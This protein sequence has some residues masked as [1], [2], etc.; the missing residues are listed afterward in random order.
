MVLGVVL[1]LLGS[2]RPACFSWG[3]CRFYVGK[4]TEGRFLY[5]LCENNAVMAV[6][7]RLV[8][9]KLNAHIHHLI[10]LFC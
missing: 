7:Y 1:S 6:I 9:L 2:I 4:E 5:I 10:N 3:P 8:S